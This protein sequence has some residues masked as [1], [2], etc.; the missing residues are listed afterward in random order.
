L[1]VFLRCSPDPYDTDMGTFARAL[2][3]GQSVP[4]KVGELHSLRN[5]LQCRVNIMD[6]NCRLEIDL[7][8]V[9]S[10]ILFYLDEASL[11]RPTTDG[12]HSNLR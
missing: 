12:A 5:V 11:L 6:F 8:Y 3:N 9:G 7:A 2:K 4:R 1:A 10:T